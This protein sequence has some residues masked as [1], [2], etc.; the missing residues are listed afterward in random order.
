[1]STSAPQRKFSLVIDDKMPT[2]GNTNTTTTT[3]KSLDPP[4][5]KKVGSVPLT[6]SLVCITRRKTSTPEFPTIAED[7]ELEI[8]NSY[9]KPA[10]R[11]TTTCPANITSS[12]SRLQSIPEL[13]NHL[14]NYSIHDGH[15][16]DDHFVRSVSPDEED[17]SS[18][19]EIAQSG[20]STYS[21]KNF[22]YEDDDDGDNSEDSLF[23]YSPPSAT[24]ESFKLAESPI[25]ETASLCMP[26]YDP[27]NIIDSKVELERRK[28][29]AWFN[30]EIQQQLAKYSTAV[31]IDSEEADSTSTLQHS[32]TTPV[33]SPNVDT[34]SFNTFETPKSQSCF[35]PFASQ[36]D[37]SS[38]IQNNEQ[39]PKQQKQVKSNSTGDKKSRRNG[40]HKRRL[41][42]A[43]IF[44]SPKVVEI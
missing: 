37:S 43:L 4:V 10:L 16:H 6:C 26:N 38:H 17:S 5:D 40:R 29:T 3:T 35:P 44:K 12:H 33:S 20:D 22:N 25:S 1:M 24:S 30:N 39:A 15:D 18:D 31:S 11:R 34:H 32:F 13:T 9:A 23:D 36:Q 19:K 41:T 14:N 2:F 21:F 8:E 7:E 42:C 28:S 27:F